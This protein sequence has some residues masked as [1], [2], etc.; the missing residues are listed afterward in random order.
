MS[1]FMYEKILTIIFILMTTILLNVLS[2][3]GSTRAF[4][5]III[6]FSKISFSYSLLFFDTYSNRLSI[7]STLKKHNI[8]TKILNYNNAFT[9][10][11][12]VLII[13]YISLINDIFTKNNISYNPYLFFI[14]SL[15]VN[16][17]IFFSIAIIIITMFKLEK[18]FNNKS[19]NNNLINF[20]LFFLPVLTFIFLSGYFLL[21][22][23]NEIYIL[24][25]LS[26]AISL[27]IA[28]FIILKFNLLK[29]Y[30]IF[31]LVIES[32]Q[33][34]AKPVLILIATWIC[35]YFMS[36]IN[37]YNFIFNYFFKY[38]N[39]SLLPLLFL[40][41]SGIIALCL[42]NSFLSLAISTSLC[43]PIMLLSS[44]NYNLYLLSTSTI[45]AGALFGNHCLVNKSY[46]LLGLFVSILFGILPASFGITSYGLV[47]LGLFFIVLF[48][49]SKKSSIKPCISPS[50][51]ASTLPIS[52]PVRKSLTIR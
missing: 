4:I 36:I 6:K 49:F 9:S 29:P 23:S 24:L 3:A 10:I 35:I 30:K 16:F 8:S 14:D 25:V 52:Y 20:Y 12:L 19:T 28:L 27:F 2:R 51:T 21:N 47:P 50:N 45:F 48:S 42:K 17:Y 44:Q 34:I 32:V 31:S 22:N 40:A 26:T 38:I 41:I 37:F 33:D 39:P 13:F 18:I 11:P 1:I 5:N 46:A 15:W 7:D 43:F